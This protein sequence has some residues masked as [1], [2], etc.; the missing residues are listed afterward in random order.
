MISYDYNA[1]GLLPENM[2]VYVA[3]S[4]APADWTV[5]GQHQGITQT[6][7]AT[8]V[9]YLFNNSTDGVYY[10]VVKAGSVRGS[11]GVTFDNLNITS[12]VNVTLNAGSHGSVNPTGT[13]TVGSG[14]DF[15]FCI[16]PDAGYHVASISVNGT[17][18]EGE[19][20]NNSSVYFYTLYNVTTN[21]LV[22]ITF[23]ASNVVVS[24]YVNGNTPFGQFVPAAPET[25]PYGGNTT[26]TFNVNP[27]YHL[28]S[29]LLSDYAYTGNNTLANATNIL[30]NTTRTGD[31][32]TYDLTNIYHNKSVWLRSEST[33]WVSSTRFMDTV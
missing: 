22:D 5:I 25:L 21:S 30:A 17:Q 6:P 1:L 16:T 9:N 27:H 11:N 20:Q 4:P 26:L 32:Y 7:S 14:S 8:R 28:S 33:L 29:L 23:A 24:K 12:T 3:T 31:T 13:V 19:D 15:T 10:I 2:T 18:V